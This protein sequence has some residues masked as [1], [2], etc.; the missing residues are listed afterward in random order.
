MKDFEYTSTTAIN[1][2]DTA[3]KMPERKPSKLAYYWR[4]MKW[5]WTHKDEPGNRSKWRRM[6]REVGE[7]K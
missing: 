3:I 2:P 7:I 1:L 5:L 4:M 6:M